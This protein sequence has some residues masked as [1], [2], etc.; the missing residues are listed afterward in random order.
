LLRNGNAGGDVGGARRGRRVSIEI[1]QPRV[2]GRIDV[3][4]SPQPA[5][6]FRS[7]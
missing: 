6:S 3:A 2:Y 4:V 1:S 5:V 7:R